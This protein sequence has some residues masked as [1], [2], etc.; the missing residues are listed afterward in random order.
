MLD[1]QAFT[2]LLEPGVH[3]RGIKKVDSG[4][5]GLLEKRDRCRFI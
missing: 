5:K 1:L 2:M 3:I 4:V